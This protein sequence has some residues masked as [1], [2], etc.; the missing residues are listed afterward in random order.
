MR[1]LKT[2]FNFTFFILLCLIFSSSFAEESI[3][4]TTYYPS[5]YG[6]YRELRSK[7][8]AI[9]DNYT[10]AA[11]YTW[12]EVNGDGG[13]VDYLADLVVEGNVGIG[14]VTPG[15]L[16]TVKSAVANA[17]PL[18]VSNS[19]TLNSYPIDFDLNSSWINLIR[20][21]N[22]YPT[23]DTAVAFGTQ[24]GGTWYFGIDSSDSNKFKL[25]TNALGVSDKLTVQTDGKVGIGTTT[26]SGKLSIV[27][28]SNDFGLDTGV[29][30]GI[31]RIWYKSDGTG[32]GLSLG[33][34]AI[35][36]SYS[37]YVYIQDGGNVGIGTTA[38]GAWLEVGRQITGG[39]NN[40]GLFI[41]LANRIGY[42][43]LRIKT[44]WVH[45][46]AGA[47]PLIDVE[48]NTTGLF[49]LD[50]FGDVYMHG[51]G[52]A[53]GWVPSSDRALKKDISYDFKYG[54]KEIEQLKPVAYIYKKDENNKKQIGF[55]AQ[56]VRKIIPELVFGEE[57]SFGLSYDQL[58]SVLVRGMQEQ[59][60]EIMAQ[61]Q[62]IDALRQE[63]GKL[64]K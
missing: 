26:P 21:M 60:K 23:G 53:A 31:G 30:P 42:S 57:G 46:A 24:S 1:R 45:G 29:Y 9:G 15:S 38:P 32:Y 36:N 27:G 20:L 49:L 59:Q 35:D 8:L 52:H 39:T 51:I 28:S 33:R 61:Q 40:N 17:Y 63:V 56:D 4:I 41:N 54:L 14:T 43:A 25:G 11:N 22:R 13:Q 62:Q 64:K 48:D 44:T 19:V 50:K 6:S 7:R 55:I 18:A 34:K 58:T 2:I 10:D 5:P 3:T 37:D 12:E 16:L 47:G